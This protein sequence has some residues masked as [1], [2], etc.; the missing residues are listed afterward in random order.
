MAPAVQA[1]MEGSQILLEEAERAKEIQRLEYQ[2]ELL[3]QRAEIAKYAEEIKKHGGDVSDLGMQGGRTE[4]PQKPA[5][6]PSRRPH[7]S[8]SLPTLLHIERDRAAFETEQGKVLG[9]VGQ[10]L[11]G[12]FR[13][14]AISMRDGVR[15][16]KDGMRYDIDISW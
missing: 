1:D 7:V 8:A 3:K 11:P 12:G 6:K 13:V 15:L 2:A 4:R 10:I 9:R 14:V 16:H 5:S